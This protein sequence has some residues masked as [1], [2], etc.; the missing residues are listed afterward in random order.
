MVTLR[1]YQPN[2]APDLLALFQDTIRRVNSRD[3]TPEQIRAWASDDIDPV[4]WA[5]RF[6][7]R[8]AVVAEDS[9]WLVGFAELE[10]DGHIGRV[11][12]SADHQRQ[13]IG[14]SMLASI[15]AQAR[16]QR[17]ARLFT[18]TSITARPF[19]EA[20]GFIVLAP[21][22]VSCRGADFINYRMER[23]LD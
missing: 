16:R 1:P 7:G 3:Y 21:Q 17:I 23:V 18:E 4:H 8:F 12:V 20:Q 22:V 10:A 13:G 15:M 6:V 2:D 11:Y 9:G 5:S 19:F 14:R